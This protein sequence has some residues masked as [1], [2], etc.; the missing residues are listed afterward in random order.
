[1][2]R[3][4]NEEKSAQFGRK[5]L[6]EMGLPA[7]EISLC[8]EMILATKTHVLSERHEIN[9]FTDADLSILGAE[10]QQYKT[11]TNQIRREYSVYPDMLYYPGRRKVVEHFLSMPAIFKTPEFYGRYEVQ[12]RK[13]L[14][15]EHNDIS[16]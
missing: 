9:L 8:S 14:Q 5:R 1:V 11:Y 10:E 3:K 4:N 2:L 7:D 16:L 6:G 12:A 13:N 15:K